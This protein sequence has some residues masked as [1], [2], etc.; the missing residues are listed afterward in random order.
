[1]SKNT[2]SLV[3]GGTRGIGRAVVKK[4]S[5]QNHLV[6]VIGRREPVAKDKEIKNVT[7]HVEDITQ[8]EKISAL[9]QK[10]ISANGPVSNV[11]FCQRFRGQDDPWNGEWNASLTATKEIIEGLVNNKQLTESSSVVVIGSIVSTA[12]VDGQGAGYHVGK[13]AQVQLVR[14]FASNLGKKGVRVN[15]V[16]PCTVLKEESKEFYLKDPKLME[17]YNNLIPVGR[18]GISEDIA[19]VVAF[20]CSA[21]A[22]FVTGQNITV[23]GGLSLRWPEAIARSMAGK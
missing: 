17:L 16:S 15:C 4:F 10:I 22:G 18:M 23:D 20:L 21:D 9:L 13:A 6:S 8:K 12:G 14:F 7:Y 19:N 11:V 3:I 2:H 5:D 1:M